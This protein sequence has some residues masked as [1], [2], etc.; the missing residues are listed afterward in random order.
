VGLGQG[1]KGV[2]DEYIV[3]IVNEQERNK[4]SN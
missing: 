1:K 2:E 4:C 3:S